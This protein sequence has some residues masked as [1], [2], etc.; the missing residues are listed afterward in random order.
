[1]S[2]STTN[3]LLFGGGN[4]F[5]HLVKYLFEK[6]IKFKIFTD[7]FHLGENIND[8]GTLRLNLES[9]GIGYSSLQ[10]ISRKEI[11]KYIS[12]DTVGLSISAHWIFKK[13]IIVCFK[14]KFYN[15]HTS[16]LPKGRGGGGPTWR[17]L[18]QNRLGGVTIHRVVEGIDAGDIAMQ[19]E[20][21]YPDEC[22]IPADYYEFETEIVNGLLTKF[23]G[24]ILSGDQIDLIPQDNI[25]SEYFPRISTVIN[26][27]IDWNWSAEEIKLFI[28]A[29]D[30][31]YPGAIT[32][33]DNKKVH[34]KKC[35][36]QKS[37]GN[38]HPFQSGI[39]Y[40]ILDQNIFIAAK[41]GALVV[42]EIFNEEGKDI[43]NSVKIG[44]R[45]HTPMEHLEKS[46]MSKIIYDA[47]GLKVRL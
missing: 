28:N 8:I 10:S 27:H 39:I 25:F 9:N 30:D 4:I 11:E 1:M 18:S 3:F 33:I 2:L 14:G 36:V 38:F 22:V 44:I 40:R 5:F 7:E 26:G 23:I 24:K 6:N 35:I 29:F 21:Y 17:I 43:R 41:D 12:N 13:D 19:T 46:K 16:R 31:P 34:L 37:E 47:Y 45:L 32:F 20:F 15:L 42:K